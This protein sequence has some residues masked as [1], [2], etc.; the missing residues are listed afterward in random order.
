MR[1]RHFR[2]C[3]NGCALCARDPALSCHNRPECMRVS[4]DFAARVIPALADKLADPRFPYQPK[5]R[6]PDVAL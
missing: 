5:A 2:G 4:V 1:H 3:P 6:L